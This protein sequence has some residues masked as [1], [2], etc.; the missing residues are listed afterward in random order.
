LSIS[1]LLCYLLKVPSASSSTIDF[2][3]DTAAAAKRVSI[4][5]SSQQA[6]KPSYAHGGFVDDTTAG[7]VHEAFEGGYSQKHEGQD[8]RTTLFWG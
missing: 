6:G 5:L 2:N 8:T 1:A 4:V 3:G 7:V